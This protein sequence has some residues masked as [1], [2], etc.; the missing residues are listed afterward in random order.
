MLRW[1]LRSLLSLMNLSKVT[2]RR[3][4]YHQ[5]TIGSGESIDYRVGVGG[6]AQGPFRNSRVDRI[7]MLYCASVSP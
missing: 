7:I 4:V 3:L 1:C 6:D 5:A 2:R